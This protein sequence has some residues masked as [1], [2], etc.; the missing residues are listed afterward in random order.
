[1]SDVGH[2]MKYILN[3][4]CSFKE[5]NKDISGSNLL[6]PIRIKCISSDVSRHLNSCNNVDKK[7]HKKQT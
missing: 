6:D 7:T 4:F 2:F 1:M 3:G 5:N